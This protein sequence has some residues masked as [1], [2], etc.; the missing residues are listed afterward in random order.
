[1]PT[2]GWPS[3]GMFWLWKGSWLGLMNWRVGGL[4]AP[5]NAEF[6]T[7]PFAVP[8]QG[9]L[10]LDMDS[11]WGASATGCLSAYAEQCQGYITVEL[12]PPTGSTP[13]PG[14]EKEHC[15]L[16]RFH[17]SEQG[18]PLT[19]V[20]ADRKPPPPVAGQVVRARIY[21]RDSTVY[22]IGA[23]NTW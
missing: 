5:G 17:G 12:L 23:G 6:T 19:W 22:A 18:M 1:M 4:Y 7:A 20:G 9:Y 8:E 11:R 10:W 2:P 3:D 21:F 14:Y 16:A 13:I 15:S